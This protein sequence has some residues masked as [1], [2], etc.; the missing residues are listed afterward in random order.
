MKNRDRYILKVN[1]YDLMMRILT[2]IQY[3]DV[4][5]PVYVVAGKHGEYSDRCKKY[6]WQCDKCCQS[7]LNEEE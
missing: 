1:E 6:N 7:W 5:C 3:T 4:R 2:N